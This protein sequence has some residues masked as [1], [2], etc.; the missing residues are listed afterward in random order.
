M[1]N[2]LILIL[3]LITAVLVVLFGKNIAKVVEA[4][5]SRF[6]QLR[7][8]S[9]GKYVIKA[10]YNILYINLRIGTDKT[11]PKEKLINKKKVLLLGASIGQA[12]YINQYFDFIE[13]LAVYRFDKT[14]ALQ[15]YLAKKGPRNRPDAIILKECA[16]FI[17]SN[18]N[19]FNKEIEHYKMIYQRMVKTTEE[20]EIVPIVATVC[21]VAYEGEHLN[22]ILRFNDW[23]RQYA[24]DNALTLM[25]IEKAVRISM[26]DRRLRKEIAQKDGLHLTRKAYE[27]HLNPLV[28]PVLLEAFKLG[29]SI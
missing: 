5:K 20:D 16:A 11:H 24:S 19:K 22:N 18:T 3:V 4:D 14:E 13:N 6:S 10:A 26:N 7:L 1:K 23:L 21:P 8:S 9:K 15:E 12:W 29:Q 27:R 25:D 28:V 17:S 2:F